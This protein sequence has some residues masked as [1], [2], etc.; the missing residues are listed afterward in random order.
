[1]PI[2]TKT[3]VCLPTDDFAQ[4]HTLLNTARLIASDFE[5][6]VD[7][8]DRGDLLFVDPPYKTLSK[9]TGFAKYNDKLFAWSD[10]I[11]LRDCLERARERG[12]VIVATNADHPS[13]RKLY[14]KGFRTRSL[15]RPSVIASNPRYRQ[16][17]RELLITANEVQQS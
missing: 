16:T 2:G 1:M 7:L 12:A 14:A 8:A 6:V 13:V 10:Q 5:D 17:T 15:R 3:S 11:R 9:E 4:T